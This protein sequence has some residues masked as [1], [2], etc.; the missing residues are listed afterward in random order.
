ME[1]VY[2]EI[3]LFQNGLRFLSEELS[4]EGGLLGDTSGWQWMGPAAGGLVAGGQDGTA[5]AGQSGLQE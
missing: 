3:L 2:L 1:G 5:P 4:D